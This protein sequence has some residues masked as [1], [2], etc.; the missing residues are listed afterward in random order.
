MRVQKIN[1]NVWVKRVIITLSAS[2]N[3]LP[4]AFHS[5]TMQ[6]PNVA[7]LLKEKKKKGISI[8]YVIK[9]IVFG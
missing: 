3:R 6:I 4:I 8:Y 2:S 9:L 7:N 1:H 5:Y